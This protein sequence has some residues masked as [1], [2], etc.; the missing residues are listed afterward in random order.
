MDWNGRYDGLPVPVPCTPSIL[1]ADLATQEF[2]CDLV[3]EWK[4]RGWVSQR[5]GDSEKAQRGEKS[6]SPCEGVP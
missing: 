5:P 1:V 3:A 2:S 4:L 6:Q